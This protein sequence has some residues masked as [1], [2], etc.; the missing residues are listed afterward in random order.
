MW[1]DEF[2]GHLVEQGR[3]PKTIE[4]YQRMMRQY[5]EWFE[6]TRRRAF[7]PGQF[8]APDMREYRT[9][10]IEIDQAATWNLRL[11]AFK[12]FAMFAMLQGWIHTDPLQGVLP[13]KQ[14]LP[15]PKA[16][17]AQ[18]F[19]DLRCE[20]DV[21]INGSKTDYGRRRGIRDRA[22]MAL[23]AYAM[24]RSG[25]VVALNLDN[26][27]LGEKSGEVR[28]LHGKGDKQAKVKL[29]HEVRMAL[30]EWVAVHPGG[31]S[32][33]P[34][35]GTERISQREVQ[36][37]AK[38]IGKKCSINLWPHRLRHTG[39]HRLIHE[40]HVALATVQKLA[41]HVRG[42]TTLRYA[43]ATDEQLSLAIEN[44]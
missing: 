12:A 17:N 2:R 24:L 7:E 42:E 3:S 27:T 39:V 37:L 36:R 26:I 35:K 14:D 40:K 13:R 9:M 16:L 44:L 41:R 30:S 4:A 6:E 10:R 25:E 29:G 8:V 34:G 23:M 11:A 38:S 18:E 20:L 33:F 21:Q 19:R 1:S 28:I 22:I 15:A 31:E 32:L 5:A 43:V